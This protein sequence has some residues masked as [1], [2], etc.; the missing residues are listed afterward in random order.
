MAEQ[1]Q[2]YDVIIVGGGPVGLT[3]GAALA[4]FGPGLRVAL[5]DRRAFAVPEDGRAS[6]LAA[7]VT[8]VF[9]GLGLWGDLVGAAAP[10][11]AMRITDSGRD[12]IARPLF[13]S[14]TGDVTP[15]RPYA[16]MVPNRAIMQSLLSA[17][18]G[19]ADLCG[20][21]EITGF[22]AD[23]GAAALTFSDGRRLTAPL[24]VAADGARSALR[25]MAGIGVISHD[26]GQTG[27]VTTIGHALDHDE[28]AYEHF[29][30]QGPFASL[31]LPGKRS[32]LVWTETHAQAARLKLRP[33]EELAPVIEAAMGSCLGKVE[34][35][36]AVQAFP[37]GLQMARSFTAARLALIGDAAHVVHPIAG[38]GLNLGVQ[39]VAALAEVIVEALRLGQDAGAADVLERY[40]R[41]RRFDVALMGMVTD[42]LNRLFSNDIA[43][44]RAARDFGLGVVDRLPFVKS[45][46]IRRA[47][48][49][50]SDGPKLMRGLPI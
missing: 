19:A 35:L 14:F 21:V 11:K 6:A 22:T 45:G 48:A 34:V 44:V 23:A 13:L 47:A 20:A 37:L 24:V 31:P 3:L 5:C 41:W 7:G 40:Q 26:Y 27:L 9:E 18:T 8:R 28:T 30:P 43:P 38:Q 4:R 25:G 50:D 2:S 1:T 49:L 29:R 32:S 42:S 15:G 39:D 16:H 17:V 10:V 46:L 33:P 36:E 12:D